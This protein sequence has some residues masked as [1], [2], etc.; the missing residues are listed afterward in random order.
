[1]PSPLSHHVETKYIPIEKLFVKN[2][3]VEMAGVEPASAMPSLRR[4]YNNTII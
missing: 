1:L 2:T 3:L 4:N